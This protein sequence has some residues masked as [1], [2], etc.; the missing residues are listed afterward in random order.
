MDGHESH[1]STDFEL[2]CTDHGIITLC[3]PAH[4]SHKLQPLDVGCFRALKRAYSKAIEGLMRTHITHISKEDFFQAFHTA[5]IELMTKSNIKGGFQG[6]SLVPYD[7]EYVISQLNAKF[8][9]PTPPKT[10]SSLPALW[11]PKTPNNPIKAQSQTNYIKNRIVQHQ[12]SSLTSI[13]K[14]LQQ[15]TKGTTKVMQELAL[16]R[17]EVRKLRKANEILSRRRYT[18]KKRLQDKGSL[19]QAEA[20]NLQSQIDVSQQL[21]E[22]DRTSG[23]RKKRVLQRA[24]RCRTCGEPGHNSR[25]CQNYPETSEEEDSE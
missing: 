7:P 25:T 18:K 12:N 1:H 17:E 6:A 11:E 14:S 9:T 21:K 20:E 15:F 4:S 8:Y 13:I 16:L 19:T 24:P 23:S 3:M 2:Y 22:E 10:S 5:Y